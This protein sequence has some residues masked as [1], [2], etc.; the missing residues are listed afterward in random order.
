MISQL[1]IPLGPFSILLKLRNWN[2]FHQQKEF[3]V[4]HSSHSQILQ[5]SGKPPKTGSLPG[6]IKR[7][8]KRLSVTISLGTILLN[9]INSG[10]NK[11]VLSLIKFFPLNSF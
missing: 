4:H 11:I 2:T 5:I 7:L 8:I 1:T 6:L 10:K 3:L 9:L